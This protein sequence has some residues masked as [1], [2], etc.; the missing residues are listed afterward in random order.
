MAQRSM[1]T[2]TD[3]TNRVFGYARVSSLDQAAS[4][5]SIDEQQRKIEARASEMGWQ[6]AQVFIDAGI[7]GGTPLAKRP[8]GAQLL[9][10]LRPGDVVVASRM[11]RMFRSSVDALT[12]IEQLKAKKIGLWLLDLGGDVTG[13]GISQLV[14]S[15]LGAV[16]EFERQLIGERIRDAKGQQRRAQRHL[17]GHRPFG[18]QLAPAKDGRAAALVEDPAE[19]T[20]IARMRTM[21]AKG[22]TLMQIRDHIRAL[23]LQISHETVRAVLAR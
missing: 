10:A 21:R 17:G 9:A 12:T 4:G 22:Q 1:R 11:D 3:S 5:I 20:A 18:W 13:N 8:A 16:A 19:Q 14:A 2:P 15:I 23:G 6:L 7:S